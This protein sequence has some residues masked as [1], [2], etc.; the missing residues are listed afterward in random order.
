LFSPVK[1]YEDFFFFFV[2]LFRK[3]SALY[4]PFPDFMFQ[5]TQHFG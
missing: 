2:T 3:S 4:K 5:R 1:T